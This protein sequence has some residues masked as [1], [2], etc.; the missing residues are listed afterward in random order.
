MEE[1]MIHSFLITMAHTTPIHQNA[2]P[3][4]KIIQCKDLPM[5][6][7]PHK[8]CH[9]L[10][11]LNF[12]NTLPWKIGGRCTPNVI[13]IRSSIKLAIPIE[14]PMRSVTPITPRDP[15]LRRHPLIP[16]HENPYKISNS[17]FYHFRP[18]GSILHQKCKHHCH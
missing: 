1:E 8:K 6:C 9:P 11:N 14:T 2:S 5:N 12:L 4:P 16:F 17:K 10:R 15:R 18:P 13:V 7:C 3:K